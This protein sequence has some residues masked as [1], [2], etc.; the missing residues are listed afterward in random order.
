MWTYRLIEISTEQLTWFDS[1]KKYKAGDIVD[2]P[3]EKEVGHIWMVVR[4]L[5]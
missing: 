5:K 4:E 1:R 3:I 2:W